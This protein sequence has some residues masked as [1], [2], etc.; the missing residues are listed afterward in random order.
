MALSWNE[1]R[2]RAMRF[3]KE[4][5]GETRERAEK[6]TFWNQ[7]FEVFGVSRRR[8]ATFEEPVKKLNDQTG[9]IDLFWKG[10][11]IVEHKSK[12][13]DLQAAFEQAS[14]YFHGLKDHEIPKFILVSDFER[15]RLY[16]LDERTDHEFHISE[17]HKHIKLF[18]FMA[19]YQKREFK[20]QDPVNIKA[21]E[22]LGKLHDE[23][24]DTGYRAHD[25]EIFLVRILFCLFAD[26]TGIFEKDTFKDFI[27]VK[28]NEDGS[29]VGALLTQLF[30]VLNTPRESR[31]TKLDDHLALFPY[32]NGQLFEENLF[33]PAFD[34]RMREILLTASALDWG[35]I[36][37]AIFGS[38]FQSVMNPQERRNLG[39]HYTS[40]Q[41]ILK[42][43][44]PLFLD[45]LWAEFEQVRHNSKRLG[46]FHVKLS[47]LKF[48][49]PACGCGNFLIITYRE[50]RLLELAVLKALY[51][52]Q[53]LIGVSEMARVDVDQFY[54]IEIDEWPARIAEV[55]MW[56]ID[57]QMNMLISEAFG[58]YYARLPL[59]KSA[60]IVNANALRI[61]WE[62]VVPKNELSYILGNP[63]FIGKHY[64]SA[65]QKSDFGFVFNK[66]RASKS[67]DFVASWF[68]LAARYIQDSKIEVALVSTNSICQGEQV[69]VL[70]NHLLFEY[71]IKINFAH[72]TFQWNNE[73]KGKAAV[74]VII[75]GFSTFNRK[76]KILF[77]YETPKSEPDLIFADNISPY[78][79]TTGNTIIS[80]RSKPICNVPNLMWG[81]KP[82]DGGN[83][84]LTPEEKENLILNEPGC[85]KW[86]RPLI[87]A[88]EFLHGKERFCLWLVGIKPNELNQL[89]LIRERANAVK[90][91]RESSVDSGAQKIAQRPTQFRDLRNP[92]TAIIIPSATS[93]H[94]SYIPM[95]FIDSWPIVNN[96]CHMLPEGNLYHFG[97]LMSAMHMAWVSY[98]CGRLE[99]RYR[100]SK[101]IVYNNFP[102]PKD[103][104]D[105][106]VKAVEEKAQAVLDARALYPDSSLAEL[107]DPLLM[108]AELVR[109]HQA[110]D[111]AVDL[112]YRPQAFPSER[113][114]IEYLF[115]LY[116]EYLAPLMGKQKKR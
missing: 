71:G 1:I 41:N 95:G 20:E 32:V 53:G 31:S 27:E 92:K 65:Q 40:E 110:L 16:D 84:L 69:G 17:L 35:K 30:Q 89:K 112:C 37:P 107:Y 66:I 14:D 38:M 2:D 7:F 70:W 33:I 51:G 57:H 106:N 87:S 55:A 58:Q 44:K 6:D 94:R 99:S 104:S 75:V 77:E 85:E 82:V 61:D 103:P 9:F 52:Q 13:K 48:F 5:E 98:T 91:M 25:L 96:S 79:V 39:A 81:N 42:L 109:A 67:L 88:K 73:A 116:E 36:S 64:Q 59:K 114:R 102:W 83:L 97:I 21:A 62:E 29:N 49:D 72:K 8:V 60:H 43:I 47:K 63:P 28:T 115:Q 15:F 68:L 111:K 113:L 45:D 26:D 93:E 105:K 74:H 50:L 24:K 108:P 80:S 34:S 3:S 86:I 4:W 56:L 78:L 12:G 19:G 18:G 23:L 101:D 100:Y 10:Q 22:L 11:I 76:K 90:I 46:E 54:G